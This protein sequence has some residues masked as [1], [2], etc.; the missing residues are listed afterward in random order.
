MNKF[1]LVLMALGVIFAALLVYYA[2]G[3]VI[4]AI[5]SLLFYAVLIAVVALAGAAAY[6]Y[7]TKPRERPQLEESRADRELANTQ[8]VLEEY[9]QKILR[10]KN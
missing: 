10:E 8:N 9:R 7:L 2:A 3:F 4:G 6:K 5:F 1:K